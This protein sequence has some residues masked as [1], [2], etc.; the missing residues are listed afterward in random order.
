MGEAAALPATSPSAQDGLEA[1]MTI[2]GSELEAAALPAE[3]AS[4]QDGLEANMTMPMV[5]SNASLEAEFGGLCKAPGQRCNA[6]NFLRP[7]KCCFG[8]CRCDLLVVCYCRLSEFA[9][10]S[11]MVDL[12]QG[13]GSLR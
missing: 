2:P 9:P 10:R 1:N 3:L 6:A 4:A 5:G 11:T 7:F 13:C 12:R 8:H